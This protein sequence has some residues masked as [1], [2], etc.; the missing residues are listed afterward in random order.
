MTFLH[1]TPTDVQS[2]EK[3][4]KAWG[5]KKEARR[6]EGAKAALGG[7]KVP[8]TVKS[9][10]VLPCI[11]LLPWPHLQQGEGRTLQ[12]SSLKGRLWQSQ[13]PFSEPGFTLASL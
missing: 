1:P 7:R 4:G 8:L 3:E 9:P 5:V 12:H 13:V 11:L 2:H 10:R 6:E